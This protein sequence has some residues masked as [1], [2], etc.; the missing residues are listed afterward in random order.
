M[1]ERSQ[2]SVSVEGSLMKQQYRK[3]D[4]YHPL[5]KSQ[6]GLKKCLSTKFPH[7][8]FSL[9][10]RIRAFQKQTLEEKV[11]ENVYKAKIIEIG[12]IFELFLW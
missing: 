7:L 6:V 9:A 4:A 12:V 3:Q 10:S 1:D 11:Q 5:S 2:M 8:T